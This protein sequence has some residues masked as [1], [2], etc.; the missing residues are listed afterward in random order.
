M[1]GLNGETA[2]DAILE[3]RAKQ[4]GSAVESHQR[5]AEVWSGILNHPVSAHDVA[6]CMT[7]L[8]LVRGQIHPAETDSLV[9]ARGYAAI[10]QEIAAH[11][12][13]TD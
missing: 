12:Q 1:A 7:G 13:G 2:R 5:I 8:K 3:E 10:A 11:E 4:W 6:L 9:D